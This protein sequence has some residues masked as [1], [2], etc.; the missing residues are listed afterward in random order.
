MPKSGLDVSR[1]HALDYIIYILKN[2]TV[3][4]L[5]MYSLKGTLLDIKQ[6]SLVLESTKYFH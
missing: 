4:D 5:F 6:L 3:F 2:Q 1:Y